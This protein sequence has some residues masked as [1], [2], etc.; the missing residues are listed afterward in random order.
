MFR[1]DGSNRERETEGTKIV[2]ARRNGTEREQKQRRMRII[3]CVE[4]VS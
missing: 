2:H 1:S 3:H 4:H